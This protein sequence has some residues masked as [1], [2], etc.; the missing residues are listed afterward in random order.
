MPSKP[1]RK[2]EKI[3]ALEIITFLRENGSTG[4]VDL[5]QRLEAGQTSI[6]SALSVLKELDLI[7]EQQPEGFPVR[8]PVNLTEK[9]R[10]V[11]ELLVQVEKILTEGEK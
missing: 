8:R 9:G 11:A 4:K 2:L 3:A 5:V 6:Y 7:E 1:I 10:R